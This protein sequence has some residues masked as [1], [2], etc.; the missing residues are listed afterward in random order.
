MSH[1]LTPGDR[2]ALLLVG[3]EGMDLTR[4]AEVLGISLSAIKMRVHRA[5]KRLARI[6]EEPH[7]PA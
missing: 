6:L 3:V 7:D 2:E 4:G 5:R 1:R